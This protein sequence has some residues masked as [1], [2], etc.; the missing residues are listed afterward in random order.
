M[1]I[2]N[3]SKTRPVLETW[4]S[5]KNLKSIL[6]PKSFPDRGI[7]VLK[8]LK[9]RK[10]TREISERN[11]PLDILSGLLWA[12]WGVNRK[13]GPFGISGRTAASASNSQEIELL[14]ALHEAIYF[15]DALNHRLVPLAEG[16]WRKL[17]IGKGQ[18]E[19]MADAPVQLIYLVNIDRLV[20]TSG[21]RE[22][23]L[24]DPETQKSY[25]YTDTGLIAANVYLYAASLGMACWFHNCNKPGL[26]A[27]LKLPE[28]KRALLGQSVGYPAV[29]K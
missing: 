14:V 26:A 15:Y 13:K 4:I 27:K 7:S 5:S 2:S 23:G 3:K 1:P 16:D 17:A 19:F 11:L 20:H 9:R 22:P 29:R 21:Y 8:A 24:R 10:T 28:N 12:A 6:L 18:E 25:Y